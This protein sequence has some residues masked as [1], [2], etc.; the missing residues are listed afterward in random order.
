MRTGSPW[1]AIQDYD[2]RRFGADILARAEQERWSRAVFLAGGLPFMWREEAAVVRELVYQRLDLAPGNDVLVIGEAVAACG[3]E[4]DL[5]ARV[6]HG[7]MHIVDI[8]DEARDRYL[9]GARGADGQLATWR[10]SYADEFANDR[11]DAIAV[12][13]GVQHAEDWAATGRDLVR[14]LKPGRPIVMAEIAFGPRFMLRAEADLHLSYLVR[15]LFDRMGWALSD[16]PYHGLEELQAA[17]AGTVEEI[18]TFEWRGAEV[19]WGR[20]PAG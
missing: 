16:F 17:F 6:G 10:Y 18:G 1:D 14:V 9:A 4:A 7:E 19:F 11:F 13:Q 3:F 15:K 20:K 2:V 5:R 12:L 8:I